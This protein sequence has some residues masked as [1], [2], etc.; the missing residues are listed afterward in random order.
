MFP[1]TT[2][3]NPQL[4]PVFYIDLHEFFQP[5]QEQIQP[6]PQQPNYAG[7]AGQPYQ[8]LQ[9]PNYA[10][11]AGR[12]YQP[13][14]YPYYQPPDLTSHALELVQSSSDWRNL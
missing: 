13:M 14:Y 6:P 9:Q 1:G 12:P 3:S 5:Q 7:Y 8:M 2:S 11:Y 10:G 4:S